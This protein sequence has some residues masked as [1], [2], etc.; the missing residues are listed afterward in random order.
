MVDSRLLH[1]L[2]QRR[3]RLAATGRQRSDLGDGVETAG[4]AAAAGA[5]TATCAASTGGPGI[6]AGSS[7]TMT[8]TG[9]VY[10]Y[11]RF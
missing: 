9:I 1:P 7:L 2:S 6:S 4:V 10:S 5:G 11:L 3:L 8:M